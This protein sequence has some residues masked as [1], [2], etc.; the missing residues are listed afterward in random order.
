MICYQKCY[1]S[2]PTLDNFNKKSYRSSLL[3][4][5]KTIAKQ[6]VIDKIKYNQKIFKSQY[7][8]HSNYQNT[9]FHH[10]KNTVPKTE[11]VK[12]TP[13]LALRVGAEPV[14]EPRVFK[15]E[16]VKTAPVL[17]LR[18]GAK[19]GFCIIEIH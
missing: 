15:T 6:E 13:V 12:T 1:Q 18:V 9:K 16:R 14:S 4:S 2:R 11:R 10:T 8:L 5:T 17:A 3:R 7:L 19:P